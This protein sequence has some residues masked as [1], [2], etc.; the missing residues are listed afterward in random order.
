MKTSTYNPGSLGV[1]FTKTLTILQKVIE[2]A[3]K[4]SDYKHGT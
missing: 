2:S 4:K 1:V 3:F